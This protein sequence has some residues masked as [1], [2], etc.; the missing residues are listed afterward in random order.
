MTCR[1]E[2]MHPDGSVMK[3][4]ALLDSEVLTSL[5]TE[6]LAKKLRLPRCHSNLEINEIAG[7]NISPRRTVSFKVAGVWGGWKQ[8]EVEASV[9]S[10]VTNDLPTVPVTRWKHVSD[11]EPTNTDYGLL[12]QVNILLGGKG[13]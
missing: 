5:I 4:R 8:I 3:A 7:F 6:R 9:L 11:L 2:V 10:K 13:L 12:T 1:V